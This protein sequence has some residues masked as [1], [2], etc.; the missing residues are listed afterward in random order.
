MTC[1]RCNHTTCK[2]FGYFGKRRIQRWRCTSCKSTFCEAHTKLTRDTMTANP[3][4]AIRAIQCLLE[5]CSIRSTER[6]TGLNRNT[7]MRLLIV[8]GQ[9]SEKLMDRHMRQLPCRRIQCDEIWTFLAKKAKHVRTGDPADFGDQWIYVALDAD[10]KLIP[11]FLVGKRSSANT[12]SFML[13]VRSRISDHRVQLTTDAYI[14]Y[15]KAVEESF[16]GDADFAQLTKLYGDYGKFGNERYSPGPIVEVI[17]KIRSGSP[18]PKHIS[19]S[20]AERQNL[21]MRMQLR[22]LTRLTNA[23]SKKLSHLKA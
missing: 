8:A 5:G 22:R 1:T 6:L 18:D 14:F 15:R 12:Q 9:R 23:F 2:R 3:D 10:T 4:A 7:I 13:D 16:A 20:Y 17:S 11:S 19:T 21:T